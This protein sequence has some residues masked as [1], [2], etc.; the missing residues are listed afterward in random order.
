[1]HKFYFSWIIIPISPLFLVILTKP[2]ADNSQRAGQMIID[3]SSSKSDP[4]VVAQQIKLRQNALSQ[5]E[6][7][8][9]YKRLITFHPSNYEKKKSKGKKGKQ[10]NVGVQQ[11]W[12]KTN[13]P[14]P[15]GMC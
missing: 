12:Q 6:Q 15:L 11:N 3:T 8:M 1:M 5:A 9:E 13:S 14:R 10:K 4:A 2:L 7:L